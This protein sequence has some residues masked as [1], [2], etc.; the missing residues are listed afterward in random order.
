MQKFEIFENTLNN[1]QEIA[2]SS[3]QEGS[4]PLFSQLSAT[5]VRQLLDLKKEKKDQLLDL[6]KI[7]AQKQNSRS[8]ELTL[9]DR[10]VWMTKTRGCKENCQ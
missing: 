2:P 6:K 9:A 4:S 1:L 8:K 5:V 7:N 3:N 10:N